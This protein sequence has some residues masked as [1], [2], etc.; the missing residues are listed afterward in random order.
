MTMRNRIAGL[1]KSLSFTGLH[2]SVKVPGLIFGGDYQVKK[3]DTVVFEAETEREIIDFLTA[4]DKSRMAMKTELA[5][6]LARK[7]IE[8]EISRGT[9]PANIFVTGCREYLKLMTE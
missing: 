5:I 9:D 3:A 8:L 1:L 4:L 7:R 6:R 2:L